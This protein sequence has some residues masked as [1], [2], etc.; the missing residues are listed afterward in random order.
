MDDL[1]LLLLWLL[2]VITVLLAGLGIAAAWK[3]AVAFF[4]DMDDINSHWH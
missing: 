1:F 3:A 4:S 2:A